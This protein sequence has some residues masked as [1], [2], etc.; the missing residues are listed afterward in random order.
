MVSHREHACED[1]GPYS[2]AASAGLSWRASQRLLE[3]ARDHIN[4]KKIVKMLFQYLSR[5]DV[6]N[7][8]P[9]R[10]EDI[11][12]ILASVDSLVVVTEQKQKAST[13]ILNAAYEIDDSTP[14]RYALVSRLKKI[15]SAVAT[16][17]RCE[18]VDPDVEEAAIRDCLEPIET[19]AA[20]VQ[21]ASDAADRLRQEIILVKNRL[22]SAQIRI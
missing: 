6:E 14:L 22:P 7:L 4:T 9:N 12:K 18:D 1:P 10:R 2:A 21:D 13:T 19:L 5:E 3:E 8:H 17:E 11:D 20:V 15:A 16:I